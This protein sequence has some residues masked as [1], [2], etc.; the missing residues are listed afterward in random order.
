MVPAV[1][2]R[3]LSH[4]AERKLTQGCADNKHQSCDLSPEGPQPFNISNSDLWGPSGLQP[5]IQ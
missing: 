2:M 5:G 1:Q 4:E 3:K